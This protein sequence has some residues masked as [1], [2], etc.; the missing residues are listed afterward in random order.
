MVVSKPVAMASALLCSIM[1]ISKAWALPTTP[2][3]FCPSR[4]LNQTYNDHSWVPG[5]AGRETLDIIYSCSTTL[6]LCA[7]TAFHPN[8]P[9]QD[10]VSSTLL[11]LELMVFT[12]V[13]PECTLYLALRQL[14]TAHSLSKRVNGTYRELIKGPRPGSQIMVSLR[15]IYPAT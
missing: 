1:L 2:S 10:N 13:F 7:Y 15:F 8:T 5:P 11:R 12:I 9:L 4:C 6:F 14:W 3:G